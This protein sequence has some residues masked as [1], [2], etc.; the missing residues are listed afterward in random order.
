MSTF[1]ASGSHLKS[2]VIKDGKPAVVA[3]YAKVYL[4]A[5][6]T[7]FI[8]L[9]AVIDQVQGILIG[10]VSAFVLIVTVFGPECVSYSSLYPR[11]SFI[12]HRNHGSHFE[13]A[14]TA[15]EEGGGRDELADPPKEMKVQHSNDSMEKENVSEQLE[16]A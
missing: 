2:T 12:L 1:S 15:F 10:V 8:W 6:C 4:S 11:F 7:S 9:I 13:N 5:A 3:D 14:K 16:N